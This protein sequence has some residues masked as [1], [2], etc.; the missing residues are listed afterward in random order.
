ML[1]I[2]NE[3]EGHLLVT[4]AESSASGKG[5]GKNAAN[6]AISR[7]LEDAQKKYFSSPDWV[8]VQIKHFLKKG[9]V[10]EDQWQST[11]AEWVYAGMEIRNRLQA[12]VS[13][14]T[15]IQLNESEQDDQS[16]EVAIVAPSRSNGLAKWSAPLY[17]TLIELS[18]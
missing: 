17:N 6:Q 16:I 4:R 2:Q 8:V 14:Y 1:R 9:A 18:D 13:I 11:D 15:Q 12:N 7:I 5:C 10:A 3:H